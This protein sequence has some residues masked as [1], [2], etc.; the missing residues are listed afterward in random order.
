MRN[1]AIQIDQE[2]CFSYITKQLS[3]TDTLSGCFSSSLLQKQLLTV[4][5]ERDDRCLLT[6]HSAKMKTRSLYV[7]LAVCDLNQNLIT[8]LLTV[9]LSND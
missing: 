5:A 7:F 3:Q 9:T 6:I 1:E 4:S 2:N 8:D